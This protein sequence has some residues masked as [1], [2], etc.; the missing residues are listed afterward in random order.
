[1]N[2]LGCKKNKMKRGLIRLVALLFF[3][4]ALA[5]VTVLQAYCGNEAAGIPPEHHISKNAASAANTSLQNYVQ[6]SGG[7]DEKPEQG[8]QPVQ[9]CNDD[10]CFCCCSHVIAGHFSFPSKSLNY[11][12]SGRP[13]THVSRHAN[14]ELTNFFRPPKT[15]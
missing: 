9:D 6:S 4:Y 8:D 15:A 13:H 11:P 1:M 12:S 3:V 14:S 2:S 10:A 7:S 5:D